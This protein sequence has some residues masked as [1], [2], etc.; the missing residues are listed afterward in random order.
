M[1]ARLPQTLRSLSLCCC[2][3]KSEKATLE[4][5]HIQRQYEYPVLNSAGM[6]GMLR[7]CRTPR[8]AHLAFEY[9]ADESEREADLFRLLT[10]AFPLLG[11]LQVHRHRKADTTASVSGWQWSATRRGADFR[12]RRLHDR[13]LGPC[14][15][16][17]VS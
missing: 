6:L 7:R 3:H 17:L 12:S 11:S 2:P 4:D 14:R 8:L 1:F 5:S 16:Q 9:D 10:V 15:S 13:P